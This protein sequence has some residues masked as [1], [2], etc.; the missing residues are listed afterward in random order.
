MIWSHVAF[1]SPVVARPVIPFDVVGEAAAVV[2]FTEV[3]VLHVVERT[4][5]RPR[6]N[7][8]KP[9][10]WASALDIPAGDPYRRTVAD[11]LVERY[12]PGVS[13]ADVRRLDARLSGAVGDVTYMGSVLIPDD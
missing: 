2:P 5:E 12:W 4:A 3:A 8:G 10:I 1:G 7:R 9:S 6:R 11:Y 13:A